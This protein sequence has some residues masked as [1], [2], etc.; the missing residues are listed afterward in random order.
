MK[1]EGLTVNSYITNYEGKVKYPSRTSN[2]VH[3]FRNFFN[4][5]AGALTQ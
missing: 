5:T 3:R 4:R 2:P 1:V